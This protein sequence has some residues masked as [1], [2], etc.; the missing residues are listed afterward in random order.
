[1]ASSGL[2]SSI[3]GA[4]V[5]RAAALL[6]ALALLASA[7]AGAPGGSAAGQAGE[8]GGGGGAG[9]GLTV[10]TS[11]FPNAWMAERI[12]PAA[13]FA[14]LAPGGHGVHDLALT[15]GDRADVTSAD[16]VLFVGQVGFQPQVEDAVDDAEGEVVSLAAVA[17]DRLLPFPGQDGAADD[18]DEEGGDAHAGEDGEDHGDDT[19]DGHAHEEA[20]SPVD[21]HVWFD[22]A[23][24]QDAAE[25]VADAFAAVDPDK[26]EAYRG[27]AE[28]VVAELADVGDHADERLGGDCEHDA[29]V[30]SHEAYQYLLEP[31]GLQQLGISSAGGH[32]EATPQRIA[33]LSD[34]IEEEG[35]PAVLAE[36]LEG[37]R[38]AESLA[39]EAGVDLIDIHPLGSVSA[40]DG[41]WDYPAL[42]G[43]Q[44]DAFAE[45]LGCG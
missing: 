26:A 31:Y 43:E 25:A 7:C 12:A 22:P 17:G 42:L 33:E 9:E 19:G 35:I 37:R 27:N 18:H 23:I 34:R 28:E 5:H 29:A 4:S 14:H 2:A 44:V 13:E 1:M 6:S 16:V 24:M 11:V 20:G 45:A 21:P 8:A 10:V 32:A 40:D 30:V 39:R 15:P 41:E 38:D 36:P 3:E